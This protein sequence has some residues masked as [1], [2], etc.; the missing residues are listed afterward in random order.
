VQS[1]ASCA[2]DLH[3]RKPLLTCG[4]AVGV[5]PCTTEEGPLVRQHSLRMRL[6]VSVSAW[7]RL[8]AHV[9]A[10]NDH[11]VAYSQCTAGFGGS[12]R[13]GRGHVSRCSLARRR[14]VARPGRSRTL[15]DAGRS[16]PPRQLA[17]RRP[18]ARCDRSARRRM[19]SARDGI[20]SWCPCTRRAGHR[21]APRSPR[22]DPGPRSHLARPRPVECFPAWAPRSIVVIRPRPSCRFACRLPCRSPVSTT[23]GATTSPSMSAGG[24]WLAPAACWWGADQPGV[25]PD[26]PV[27]SSCASASRRSS[28]RIPTMHRCLTSGDAG[29]R[30]SSSGRTAVANR[31]PGQYAAGPPEHAV[32]YS[33]MIGPAPP[34]PRTPIGQQRPQPSPFRV[35]QLRSFAGRDHADEVSHEG[36][37]CTSHGLHN[38]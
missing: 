7:S 36:T 2:G 12:H 20:R 8:S 30:R 6:S 18:N 38:S 5:R 17:R 14:R 1:G 24:A 22:R 3:G 33:L 26:G 31:R 19:S 15:R 4:S 32:E 11:A 13:E 21:P 28:S 29:F 9:D 16:T 34:H 37:E 23:V 27:G 10:I 35:G 25:D